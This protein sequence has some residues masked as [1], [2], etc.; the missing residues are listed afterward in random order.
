VNFK[1]RLPNF[2]KNGVRIEELDE[3]LR[4]EELN[5]VGYIGICKLLMINEI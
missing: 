5:G 4:L 2:F 1:I 3:E